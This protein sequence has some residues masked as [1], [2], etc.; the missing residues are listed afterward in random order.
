MARGKLTAVIHCCGETAAGLYTRGVKL[1]R[2]DSFQTT[3]PRVK[4]AAA[5]V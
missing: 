5:A 3:S 1:D 4:V 2:C